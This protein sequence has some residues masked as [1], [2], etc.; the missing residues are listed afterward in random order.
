MR[1]DYKRLLIFAGRNK[2]IVGHIGLGGGNNREGPAAM[3]SVTCAG[4]A[5]G[6]LPATRRQKSQRGVHHADPG[7]A[8]LSLHF[9]PGPG[10]GRSE[11]DA[12]DNVEPQPASGRGQTGNFVEQRG[13]LWGREVEEKAF[14]Q[15]NGRTARLKTGPQ[16]GFGPGFAGS[17]VI[18]SVSKCH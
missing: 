12:V 2:P 7:G 15:P 6:R 16:Q 10:P 13:N 17:N 4:L 3:M 11:H 1:F 5:H 18:K 14:Q 9:D 8:G